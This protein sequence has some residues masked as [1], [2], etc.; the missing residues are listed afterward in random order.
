[1]AF[2]GYCLRGLETVSIAVKMAVKMAV[3]KIKAP[4]IGAYKYVYT[5]N[6]NTGIN[7]QY[8]GISLIIVFEIS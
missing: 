6:K 1:M 2:Y 8:V 7:I 4:N 5:E 3:K